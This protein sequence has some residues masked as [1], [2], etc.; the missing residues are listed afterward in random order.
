MDVRYRPLVKQYD[1]ISFVL[2]RDEPLKIL[3]YFG[4]WGSAKT[5]GCAMAF[6]A[7]CF[8]APWRPEYRS[9]APK[10][11]VISPTLPVLK[12]SALTELEKFLPREAILSRR[13]APHNEIELFNGHRILLR[14]GSGKIEGANVVNV[15]FDEAHAP[16]FDKTKYL[17]LQMRARDPLAP[18]RRVLASGLPETG[19]L[20]DVFDHPDTKTRRTI[21]ARTQDNLTTH[22]GFLSPDVYAEFLESC[23]SGEETRYLEGRWMAPTGAVYP[24]FD[25]GV[26]VVDIEHNKEKPC[27]LSF[28]VGNQAA[29]IIAQETQVTLRNEVGQLRKET[30]IVVV[31]QLLPDGKSVEDLCY[32]IKTD[33]RD[34]RVLPGRSKITTDPT[35]DKDEIGWMRKHFPGVT[36]VRRERGDHYWA[37]E[38]GVNAVKRALKDTLGNTRILFSRSLGATRRG[39]L[40]VLPRLRYNEFTG[41][42]VKDNTTDHVHDAVRYLVCEHLPI[43]R[44]VTPTFTP[45]R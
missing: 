18:F 22:G 24:M 32:A 42:V 15:W 7:C 29:C 44:R 23:G 28:D 3:G 33:P 5:S 4:G 40:D 11:F 1:A 31:A 37:I 34:F 43:T 6:L 9:T 8:A 41:K 21:L 10:S 45:G 16:E 25:P 19:W 20:R 14:S 13:E 38:E 30:G 39:I 26:H 27:H 12:E 36:V 17:N 35:T 2:A